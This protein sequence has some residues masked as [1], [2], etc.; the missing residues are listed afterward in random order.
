MVMVKKLRP[1][2]HWIKKLLLRREPTPEYM[3]WGSD[4]VADHHHSTTMSVAIFLKLR[5]KLSAGPHIIFLEATVD[6]SVL[7][8]QTLKP[9]SGVIR[10]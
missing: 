2:P 4:L 7:C 8:T 9:I 1:H 10:V 5:I 3:W 6:F